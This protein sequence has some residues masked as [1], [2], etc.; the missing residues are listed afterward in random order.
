M[1]HL[2]VSM[3]HLHVSMLQAWPTIHTA[4]LLSNVVSFH[5]DAHTHTHTHTHKQTHLYI[6]IHIYVYLW[7]RVVT[8]R[9]EMVLVLMCVIKIT[10][11]YLSDDCETAK[12]QKT[13]EVAER[14]P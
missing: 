9:R 7:S 5:R 6:Y 8:L 4:T 13:L 10:S 2:H 3:L 1:L 11:L 12:I 14:P